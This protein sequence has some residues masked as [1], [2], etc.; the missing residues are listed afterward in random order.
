MKCRSSTKAR[1]ERAAG[2]QAR[3]LRYAWRGAEAPFFHRWSGA[4]RQNASGCYLRL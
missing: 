1:R 2:A 3:C 4:L